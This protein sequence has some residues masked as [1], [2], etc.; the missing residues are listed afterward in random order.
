MI[1]YP[2]QKVTKFYIG[3]LEPVGYIADNSLWEPGLSW[4]FF[5]NKCYV[6]S[7]KIKLAKRK[8]DCELKISYC[9]VT[10]TFIC[11]F[12]FSLV[13]VIVSLCCLRLLHNYSYAVYLPVLLVLS[14]VYWFSLLSLVYR[15]WNS[16]LMSGW[17]LACILLEC[18]A[19]LLVNK[20]VFS[21]FLCHP[22]LWHFP[23]QLTVC[24]FWHW[25]LLSCL[26]TFFWQPF[27]CSIMT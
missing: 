8:K 25:I 4:R 20:R 17:W 18:C 7:H 15:L 22:G 16:N 10:M 27:G 19:F 6:I 13:A 12:C 9:Y 5:G 1:S 14:E 2:F 21:L 24:V 3:I 23:E 26:T 11:T